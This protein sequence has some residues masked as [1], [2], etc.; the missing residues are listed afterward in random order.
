MSKDIPGPKTRAVLERGIPIFR[1][2]LRYE[3]ELQ[4]A[5]RRGYR[6]G[7]QIVVDR[8]EGHYSR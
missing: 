7:R 3:Q 4:K 6:S 2:G 5:A 1:N 8:A